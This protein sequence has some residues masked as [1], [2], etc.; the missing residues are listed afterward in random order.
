MKKHYLILDCDT[1]NERDDQFAIAYAMAH[2]QVVLEGVISVQNN[3]QGKSGN[4]VDRYHR[5]ARK[6][7]R[8]AHSDVPTFKGS[9]KPLAPSERTERSKGVDFIVSKARELGER[10]TLVGTGPATDI[11]AALLQAP[12][13]MKQVTIVWIGGMLDDALLRRKKSVECNF[14]G[15]KVAFEVMTREKKGLVFLPGP[16][17]TDRMIVQCRA[18]AHALRHAGNPLADY[19]ASLMQTSPH[20]WWVLWDV[21]AV[22][23]AID[24]GIVEERMVPRCR[25]VRG[26]MRYD[27]RGP[28]TMRLITDID[29]FAILGNMKKLLTEKR[30]RW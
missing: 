20:A 7:M 15:D 6:L 19:L 9:R 22:A 1:K 30:R 25:C 5:E 21:A 26:R 28:R 13:V 16:G 17:L 11:A 3:P 29:E 12:D 4:T 24:F 10:L 8:L 23:V 2:P 18:L 27:E 14:C